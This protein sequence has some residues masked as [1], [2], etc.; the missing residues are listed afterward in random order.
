MRAH[1]HF[2]AATFLKIADQFITRF[3][4]GAGG[5]VAVEIANEAN[6]EPDIVHVIAVHM[7]ASHLPHPAI[8]D[9]D[10]AVARRSPIADHKMVGQP[11]PHPPHMPVIIIKNPRAPLPGAA[12]VD[13]DE[14]PAR[15]LHRRPPDRLDV[16]AGEIMVI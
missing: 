10:L 13:D 15:S 4:L 9:F 8:A 3:K 5:L 12:V 16:R 11:I 6:A 2:R 1:L 14:F 7:S